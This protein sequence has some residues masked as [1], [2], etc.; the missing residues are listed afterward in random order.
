MENA[1]SRRTERAV[2]THRWPT[3]G[4]LGKTCR[5]RLSHLT[6]RM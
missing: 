6:V 3:L 4:R 1:A 5:V 2:S